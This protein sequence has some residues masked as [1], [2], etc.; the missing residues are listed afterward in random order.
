MSQHQRRLDKGWVSIVSYPPLVVIQRKNVIVDKDGRYKLTVEDEWS[1]IHPQ[2]LWVYNKLQVSR[3]LGYE[4]GPIGLLVPRPDFYIIRPC[5]NFMGMGRHARIEYLN[6]DTE[7]LHP[8]EFWCEVFEGEHISVDYYKG[9][10]ELTVRGVRDPQDPL[11]KWKKWYKVD[12]EIPLPKLLQNLDYDWINCEFI[13]DKLIEIHLRG[14]PDFR[15]NNDSVIPVWEGD[16]VKTYI[17][18][19][20]YHRL[21]FIIDG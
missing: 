16:D 19:N 12:R 17:E 1:S 4:C 11:Y 3:V 8:G 20:D 21:G 13:G 2:D 6:G 5:I 15:Y 9:Q 7:H 18:D 14:N 10:Q